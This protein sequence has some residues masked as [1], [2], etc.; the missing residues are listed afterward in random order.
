MAIDSRVTLAN[1]GRCKALV[2]LAQSSGVRTAVDLAPV[3]KQEAVT[4]LLSGRCLHTMRVGADGCPM[5]LKTLSNLTLEMALKKDRKL[6][7]DHGC[8]A[9]PLDANPIELVEVPDTSPGK[10]LAAPTAAS[11]AQPVTRY[12]TEAERP[13]EGDTGVINVKVGDQVIW[14]R[15]ME[16]YT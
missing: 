10:A 2:L 7:A 5:T 13:T 14:S 15:R 1:C 4:A 8:G 11:H 12:P 16:D 3:D 6:Y 9:S